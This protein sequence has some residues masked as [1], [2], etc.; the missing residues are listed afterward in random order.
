MLA[1][2]LYEKSLL[3][4]KD[5]VR[6]IFSGEAKDTVSR[7]IFLNCNLSIMAIVDKKHSRKWGKS[8]I[9]YF[10]MIFGPQTHL[11]SY[12]IVLDSYFT[13]N[14]PNRTAFCRTVLKQ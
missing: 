9:S 11:V 13:K 3:K 1:S 7:A 12:V 8:Q 5:T 6:S 4:S 14:Q 2:A 10:R